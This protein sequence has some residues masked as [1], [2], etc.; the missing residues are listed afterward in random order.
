M[1]PPGT[2]GTF[3]RRGASVDLACALAS[4]LEAGPG[5]PPLEARRR[6][7]RPDRQH[8]TRPKSAGAVGQRSIAVK[9]M[10]RL[11][12]VA[13][14]P[15]EEVEGDGVMAWEKSTPWAAS[16]SSVGVWT[17]RCP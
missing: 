11:G 8:A 4:H 13:A 5:K 16:E 6:L 10:A 14:R 2:F 7:L 1:L 3:Q 15:L 9:R 12:A 17:P